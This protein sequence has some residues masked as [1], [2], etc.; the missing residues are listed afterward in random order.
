MAANT[1]GQKATEAYTAAAAL[2]NPF[3]RRIAEAIAT[4]TNNNKDAK[5]SGRGRGGGGNKSDSNCSSQDVPFGF[6][7]NMCGPM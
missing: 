6:L 4:A 7:D 1:L 2:A 5:T 3:T